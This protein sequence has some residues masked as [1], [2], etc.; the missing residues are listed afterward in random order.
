M[1]AVDPIGPA[2][3][4]SENTICSESTVVNDGPIVTAI[5]DGSLT[6]NTPTPGTLTLV[7]LD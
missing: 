5:T 1:I 6:S 3:V 7:P 2:T 4:C